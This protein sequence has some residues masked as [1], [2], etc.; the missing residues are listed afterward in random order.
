MTSQPASDEATRALDRL[1]A[2][3]IARRRRWDDVYRRLSG[4]M[5]LALAVAAVWFIMTGWDMVDHLFVRAP[6]PR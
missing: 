4:L 3:R 5:F 6:W 1:W 2:D